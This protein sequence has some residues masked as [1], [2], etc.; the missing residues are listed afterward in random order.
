[1]TE[2]AV[3][4]LVVACKECL[5]VD[6]PYVSREEQ[7]RRCEGIMDRMRAAVAVVK[8]ELSKQEQP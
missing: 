2:S 6:G 5:E 4:E 1:M 3:R 8:A 7:C